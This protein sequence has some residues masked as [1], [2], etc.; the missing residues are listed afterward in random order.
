MLVS[1]AI[2]LT[3]CSHAPVTHPMTSGEQKALAVTRIDSLQIPP[4]FG[5]MTVHTVTQPDKPAERYTTVV[6]ASLH[7][8]S[9]AW[10]KVFIVESTYDFQSTNTAFPT[11]AYAKDYDEIVSRSG[12]ARKTITVDD[13]KGYITDDTNFY[14]NDVYRAAVF[15]FRDGVKPVKA[16]ILID[17]KQTKTITIDR[18]DLFNLYK[19]AYGTHDMILKIHGKGVQAFA[20]TF[21]A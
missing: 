6:F 3:D 8:P 2:A 16:D 7:T 1:V 17:G 10:G 5:T 4:D 20:F 9:H 13:I 11:F 14:T 18:H 12:G 15:P 19:G 21:G